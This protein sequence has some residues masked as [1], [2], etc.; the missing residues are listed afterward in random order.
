MTESSRGTPFPDRVRTRIWQEEPHPENPFLAQQARCH[1]Y[2]LDEMA[3]TL[4][5]AETLF[6][7]LR[8]E[9]PNEAQK[10]LL[11][12]LMSFAPEDHCG[13]RRRSDHGGDNDSR[14]ETRG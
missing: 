1:G 4:E 6:L 9:L 13:P 5:P 7:L 2:A 10:S 11:R 12:R 14:R 3:R 8:G